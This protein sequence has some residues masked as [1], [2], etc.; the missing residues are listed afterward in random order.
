MLTKTKK[1]NKVDRLA[2]EKKFIDLKAHM[3]ICTYDER[4]GLKSLL[5]YYY[6]TLKG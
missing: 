6:V 2:M 3:H 1:L 5:D 4:Q